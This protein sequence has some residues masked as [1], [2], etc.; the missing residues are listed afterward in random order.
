[1]CICQVENIK[2]N[3]VRRKKHVK[4]VTL[5]ALTILIIRRMT[6][7]MMIIVITT[8]IVIVVPNILNIIVQIYSLLFFTKTTLSK[9]IVM[10]IS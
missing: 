2:I 4:I 9:I 7:V 10:L 6:I 5:I 3:P 1:M 8:M